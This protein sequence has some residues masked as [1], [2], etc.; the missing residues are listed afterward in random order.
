MSLKKLE[1]FVKEKLATEP[2][3]HDFSHAMRVKN[4]ALLIM[5]VFDVNQRVIEASCL[6]HDLIDRKLDVEYKVSES[7]VVDKLLE[8]DY[9]KDEV[10]H[11]IDIITNMSFSSK[12]IPDSL[13]GKIVQDADR[14]DAIGA[15]GI[16]RTFAYGGKL[17]RP[18]YG[19]SNHLDTV[20]HF[21]DKLFKLPDLMNTSIARD[22]ALKRAEF[23]EEFLHQLNSEIRGEE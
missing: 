3:G 14:L 4:N 11:I 22:V 2:T 15:I 13:E 18:M 6:V 7:D 17:G 19:D 16:A 12:R 1:N 9:T 20:S 8:L 23:M 10:H 5:A 21:H